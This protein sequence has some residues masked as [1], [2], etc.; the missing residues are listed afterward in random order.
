MRLATKKGVIVC[1][2]MDDDMVRVDMG[3]LQLAPQQIAFDADT[4]Q[5]MYP[6]SIDG[7]PIEITVVGMGNPHAVYVVNDLEKA[8]VARLGKQIAEHKRFPEGANVEFVK[9]HDI[10]AIQLRVYERGVGE[11]PACGSG[12]CAAVVAGQLRGQLSNVV[13]VKQPGGKLKVEWNG[14]GEHLFMVG[15]ADMVFFG[16]WPHA[17]L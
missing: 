13:Y 9:I 15:P 4:Q 17:S 11:T 16:Q 10:D 3:V 2:I 8:S 7:V 1:H 5:T 14:P 6:L 12:A